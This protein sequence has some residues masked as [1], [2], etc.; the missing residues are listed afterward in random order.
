[1]MLA[2]FV[3]R[4]HLRPSVSVLQSASCCSYSSA[5]SS[6]AERTI[7]EGPRNNWSRDEIKAVYDSPV[8]DLL[9]HGVN[10]P[11]LSHSH[12]SSQI[13]SRK[14]LDSCK[15]SIFSSSLTQNMFV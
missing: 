13:W 2:R 4:S 14:L 10:S 7:R 11:L 12:S 15:V 8:L 9:F 3:F 1:M 6:E 5:A